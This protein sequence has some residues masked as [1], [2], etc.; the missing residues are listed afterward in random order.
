MSCV[1]GHLDIPLSRKARLQCS[2]SLAY[3]RQSEEEKKKKRGKSVC[4]LSNT[5]FTESSSILS[6]VVQ[7]IHSVSCTILPLSMYFSPLLSLSLD[8]GYFFNFFHCVF[9]NIY[10]F[11]LAFHIYLLLYILNEGEKNDFLVPASEIIFP[12][13]LSS[14]CF[15]FSV[16][17]FLPAISL[18]G[19]NGPV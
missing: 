12:L 18:P 7:S 19:D 8:S 4:A 1:V 6:A 14:I 15:S 13:T 2:L 5:S 17:S 9:A 3:M 16:L 10:L 11:S